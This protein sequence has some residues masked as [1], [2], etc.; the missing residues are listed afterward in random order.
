MTPSG[1]LGVLARAGGAALDGATRLVAARP[2]A[3]PLHP[4]GDVVHARLQRVGLHPPTGVDWLDEPGVDDVLVRSSRAVGLPAALPDIHGLAL[5]VPVGDGR[6]GDLLLAST[7]LGRLSRFVLT[8]SWSP[9]GRPMTSLL[10]YRTPRGPLLL[11]AEA[12][13]DTELELRAATPGGG[14]RTFGRLTPAAGGG[15]DAMVSFNPVRNTVPGLDNYEWVR[16]LREPAY[17]R[18]RRTRGEPPQAL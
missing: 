18:A 17:R 12:V 7:G 8:V 10:P 5:R 13:T 15:A 3:K 16:R 2:A 1:A 9:Q 4:R 6:H 11:A 14:W